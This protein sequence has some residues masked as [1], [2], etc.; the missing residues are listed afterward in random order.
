MCPHCL[1]DNIDGP[2]GPAGINYRCLDCEWAWLG[3]GTHI[4]YITWEDPDEPAQ[5]HTRPDP[6]DYCLDA[7]TG[8]PVIY[9]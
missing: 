7:A 4:H 1:G 8:E 5:V 2:Y 3:E 6:D 9:A